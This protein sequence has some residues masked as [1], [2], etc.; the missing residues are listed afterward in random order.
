[1]RFLIDECTGPSVAH[2]L[3]DQGHEVFSIYENARG[4]DDEDILQYAYDNNY[5]LITNDKDFG[6]LVFRQKKFHRGIIIFRLSDERPANKIFI[7][8]HLLEKFSDKLK[9]KFTTVTQDTVRIIEP[10]SE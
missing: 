10:L 6:D 2:W 9:N 8:E 3:Q 7:L 4:L 5:I 1:M